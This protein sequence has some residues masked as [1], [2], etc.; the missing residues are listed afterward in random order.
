MVLDGEAHTIVGVMPR[1][2]RYPDGADLWAPVEQAVG[3]KA[4]ESRNLHWMVA[5]GRLKDGV[6]F[7]QARAAL[8]VTIEALTREYRKE[9]DWKGIR[10]VVRPLVGE[11]LGTT[12]QALLLLLCAV[13]AVL[14]IACANVANL[15]LSRSVD[16][17]REIAT[18]IMLG[19]SRAQLARQL[20]AEV[21]PLAI[22]GGALGIGIAWLALES[23]VRIAGAELP[24][25]DAI[26]L[27]LAGARRSPASCRLAVACSARSR[28]SCT[29][30]R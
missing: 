20:V 6:S 25:A 1:D 7:D 29:R 9:G 16:R 26:A 4:L 22:A 23:L 30:A 19:A 3:P 14:L 10:A 24:R 5:V 15:L 21:L 8:D 17:R 2:F 27:E 13:G 28:R 18:R 11:L 12:R